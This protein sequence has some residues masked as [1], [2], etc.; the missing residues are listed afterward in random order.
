M[1]TGYIRQVNNKRMIR[2][3]DSHTICALATASAAAGL[4]VIRVSGQEA[5]EVCASLCPFLPKEPESHR[6]Y[7]GFL[8]TFEGHEKL[9]EVL[10]SYFQKG[11]SFTGERT[12]EISCH[13]GVVI[14]RRILNELIL[15]GARTAERGE[16]TYRAFMNGRIDLVQAESVLQLVNSQTEKASRMAFR[17]LEGAL[18]AEITEALEG[19]TWVAAHLEANID[20]SFEDIVVA[21]TEKLRERTGQVQNRLNT[22]IQT[23]PAGRKMNEGVRVAI[24][25]EPNTGKSSLLNAFLCKERAIVTDLPGT[26]RDTVEDSLQLGGHQISFVDTAGLRETEDRVEKIGIDRSYEQAQEADILLYVIDKAEQ[27]CGEDFSHFV[28]DEF[29]NKE[30]SGRKVFVVRNKMDLVSGKDQRNAVY[31]E[32]KKNSA[33]DQKRAPVLFCQFS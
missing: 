6:I 9:D 32:T 12:V 11:K 4:A 33:D 18:S 22:L 8:Q 19:L 1:T 10:V 24:L 25:G 21:S 26:T 16:F 5:L 29:C 2:E 28:S 13:G 31:E 15:A 20:Y 3:Q 27:L 14:T 23:Y 30:D 7:Y 17:H